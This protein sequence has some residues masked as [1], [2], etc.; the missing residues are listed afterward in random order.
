MAL[1][2]CASICRWKEIITFNRC[3]KHPG[4]AATRFKQGKLGETLEI[5]HL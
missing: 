3:P 4:R 2:H 5:R 1:S